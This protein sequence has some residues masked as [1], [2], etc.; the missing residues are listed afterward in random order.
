MQDKITSFE[1][2]VQVAE[3]AGMDPP[4][5]AEPSFPVRPNRIPEHR[6]GGG[7]AKFGLGIGLVCLL[8]HLDHSVKVPEHLSM[9]LTLPLLGVIPRFRRTASIHRA[10]HLWTWRC[11]RSDRGRCLPELCA[12]A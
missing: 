12:P 3:A 8:E 4:L 9:G 11:A 6:R 2:L 5:I 7:A 1:F 10:G